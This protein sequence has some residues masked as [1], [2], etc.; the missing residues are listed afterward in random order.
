M[1]ERCENCHEKFVVPSGWCM[2]CGCKNKK[3]SK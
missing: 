3:G 2:L 1:G